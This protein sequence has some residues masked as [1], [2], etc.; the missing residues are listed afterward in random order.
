MNPKDFKKSTSGKCIKT[1]ANYWAFVP[2]PLP[3]AI[4]YDKEMRALLSDADRLIGELLGTGKA[5][6]NPYLLI[7]P[8][9]QREAVSSSQIEGTQTSMD[10][11]L[12]FE[13]TN[14]ESDPE[15]NIADI[16]EVQNYVKALQH[17]I[18]LLKK[19]PISTRFMTEVHE[20]LMKGV[21]G[22]HVTPGELR[23]SQNWIG[24]PGC[25]LNGAKYVPPPPHEMHECL[26]ALEKYIH[27][28]PKE[29]VLI[30][31]AYIHYQFESIHPFL[32][33]NG[34]LGR[35]LIIFLLL[36]REVLTV[37]LLY[38]SAFFNKFRSE[39]YIRLF[40]VSRSGDWD[41]WIKYFL[42]GI[43]TQAKSAIDDAHRITKLHVTYLALV[44]ES[45]KV[46]ESALKLVEE[47]FVNPIVSISV[48]SKKWNL[49]YNS[50]KNGVARLVKLGILKEKKGQNKGR[51]RNRIYLAH[52]LLNILIDNRLNE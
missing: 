11:L 52:R 14:E 6:S 34:R 29:P 12:L 27:S 18:K 16:R 9:V 31:C 30:Q 26:S 32:D 50:V 42:N 24:T 33:G 36:E 48:L 1:S 23:K 37:P 15:V 51:M 46:P 2:H 39:Y 47:I 49:P 41:A 22:G 5:I 8:Y 28:E 35:L 45:K 44:S 20:V 19:L 10:D 40:E 38:L 4:E 3:P 7:T 17:G 25:T 13:A 21:R 43:I